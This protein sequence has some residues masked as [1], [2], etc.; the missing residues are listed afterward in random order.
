MTAAPGAATYLFCLVHAARRPSLAGAPRGLPGLGPVRLIPAA[1]DLW[2]VAAEAP[3][4]HYGSAAI[5][6]QLRDLEWVALRGAAHARVVEYFARRL[7]T[8][9]MKLFTLF[10]DDARAVAHVH[11]AEARIRRV[12]QRVDGCRE[13]GVRVRLDPTLVRERA[14][15][16]PKAAVSSRRSGTGFLLAKKRER[17]VAREVLRE[18]RAAVEEAFEELA[19]LAEA[20]HRR[21]ATELDGTRV[22][23]DAALLVPTR[24]LPRFKRSVRRHVTGLAARGYR[25]ALTGPWPA[26]NF[27]G[28]SR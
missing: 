25:L 22:V 14:E 28:E 7:T 21:S 27:V 24:Q 26:Y 3:L 23:L 16:R 8:L 10:N 20:T 11:G 19:G 15:S 6:S 4:E 13:W 12:L 9:P 18:G 1:A 17:D 2:L 5:E